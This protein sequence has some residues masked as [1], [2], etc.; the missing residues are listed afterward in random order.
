MTISTELLREIESKIG[1][2]RLYRE[3]VINKG[4]AKSLSVRDKVGS[5]MMSGKTRGQAVAHVARD[6]GMSRQY[7]YR[8]LE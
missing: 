6:M 1:L 4:V 2:I 7:I 5:L 3:G 8:L